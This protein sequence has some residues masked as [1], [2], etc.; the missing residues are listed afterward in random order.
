MIVKTKAIVL[1]TI[2]Y[3][4]KSLIVKCFT[5][6]S[7]VKSYFVPTAFSKR[8][9]AGDNKS[10]AYFQPMSILE[11]EANHKNKPKLEHFKEVKVSIPYQTIS[12]DIIKSTIVLF[13]SEILHH[14][15]REEEENESLFI[16][17]ET[18]FVW[19]DTHDE[20]T[21]FHLIFLLE[22][23]KFLGFYPDNTEIHLPYFDIQEGHFTKYQGINCTS[24][25]ESVLLKKLLELKFDSSQK[26]FNSIERQQLLKLLIEYYSIHLVGFKKP[27]SL[28]VLK[29]VFS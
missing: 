14:S 20:V 25:N 5:Q 19:L 7:G 8:R 2:K 13:L 3:Q 4:E 21:N 26:F 17:L 15:I 27:K 29:E 9:S 22:L 1:S 18:A 6:S 12:F 11:I 23:T 28:E 10:I 16:F 24:E